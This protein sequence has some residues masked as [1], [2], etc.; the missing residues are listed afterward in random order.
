MNERTL[1]EQCQQGINAARGELYQAYAPRLMTVCRRYADSDD[2]AEDMLHDAFLKI[3]DSIG[4]F[5][6]Q[7]D[8]SLRAWMERVT[9][10]VA[11]DELRSHSMLNV[12][13]YDDCSCE[14]VD[15]PDTDAIGQLSEEVLTRFIS[16]LP[17]G[18][19][20]VFNLYCLEGHSHKEIA[21]LLHIK[22]KSSASQLTRA[23]TMLAARINHYIKE[24]L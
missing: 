19:R 18:Y 24:E 12:V 1:V 20:T 14:P 5:R 8:G 16:E 11:V 6:W 22:E 17:S 10:H 9:A 2:S 4:R 15:E 13:S 7:G 21:R 23:K 3:F